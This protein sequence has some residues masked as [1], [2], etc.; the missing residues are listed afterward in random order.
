MGL[1][2]LLIQVAADEAPAIIAA[3]QS[4]GGTVQQVGPILAQDQAIIDADI[5]QLQDEQKTP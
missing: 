1:V 2:G 4:R 3:V 5:K